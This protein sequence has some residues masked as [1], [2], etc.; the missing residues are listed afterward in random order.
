MGF[1]IDLSPTYFWPVPIKVP[2]GGETCGRH[3]AY[4]FEAE[5]K[6]ISQ[7]RRDEIARQVVI[8]QRLLNGDLVDETRLA[9]MITSKEI[10]DELLVGWR[11]ITDKEGEGAQELPYSESTKAQL[12]DMEYLADALVQAWYDSMPGAK[13]KN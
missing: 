13:V 1:P 3:R 7:S 5:F 2:M 6:R 8:G 4:A 9:Q 11:K 10:A 12:L